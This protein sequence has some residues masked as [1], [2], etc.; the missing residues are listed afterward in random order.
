M[1]IKVIKPQKVLILLFKNE[2]TVLFSIPVE[3]TGWYADEIWLAPHGRYNH[4][5]AI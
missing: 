2:M 5:L 1:V 4:S 3:K